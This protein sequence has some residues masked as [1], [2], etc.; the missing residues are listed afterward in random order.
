[1][2]ET[3][4]VVD[5]KD[6]FVRKSTRKE[7]MEKSLLHRS[8][9]VIIKNKGGLFLAQKRSP[10]KDIYPSH[11][12]IGV[13]GAAREN[14]GYEGTALR[15]LMEELG[16][17]GISNIQL[18]HSFLFKIRYESAM[19]NSHYKVYELDYNGKIKLQ[20][21]EISEAKFMAASEIKELMQKEKFHPVGK[22]VFEK[23]LETKNL[24]N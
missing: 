4:Y 24:G 6:K 8:A 15:E 7:V 21:E 3:I 2:E 12:D 1:M 11:W 10:N 16:I 18:M 22:I 19:L 13:T 20:E 9:R 14:E 5:E 23:Y 17:T